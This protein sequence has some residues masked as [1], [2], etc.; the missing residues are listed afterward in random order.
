MAI[1][2]F[3]SVF[4]FTLKRNRLRPFQPFLQPLLGSFY[5]G[6]REVK[7]K[8]TECTKR[9][10]MHHKGKTGCK[11][12]MQG[13]QGRQVPLHAQPTKPGPPVSLGEQQV[14]FQS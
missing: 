12:N 3:N 10:G 9:V 11:E 1:F 13:V 5:P 2:Q 14:D 4:K 6:K 8:G 7:H